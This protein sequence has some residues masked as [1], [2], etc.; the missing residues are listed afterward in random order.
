[1]LGT[2]TRRSFSSVSRPSPGS[3]S[4]ASGQ[5]AGSAAAAVSPAADGGVARGSR[6]AGAHKL[7]ASLGSAG[8]GRNR[9]AAARG[10]RRADG[11]TVPRE[12]ATKQ[13]N[14]MTCGVAPSAGAVRPQWTAAWCGRSALAPS[15]HGRRLPGG[16]PPGTGPR[17]LP[18]QR[19]CQACHR[20]RGHPPERHDPKAW[21]DLGAYLGRMARSASWPYN[22]EVQQRS[23]RTATASAPDRP[24]TCANVPI[25]PSSDWFATRSVRGSIPLGSTLGSTPLGGEDQARVAPAESGCQPLWT[26]SVPIGCP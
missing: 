22:T 7:S 13:G 18:P 20:E 14:L 5:L 23:R 3:T 15:G 24:A 21:Q 16:S 6:S 17:Q 4:I 12:S 2:E 1:M 8:L 9:E 26:V 25:R 10:A 19:L 11:A